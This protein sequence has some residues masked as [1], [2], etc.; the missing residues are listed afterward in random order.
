MPRSKAAN[1]QTLP[2]G[3]VYQSGFL[4]AGE[5]AA[6]LRE[7]ANLDFQPFHFQGY[8]ARRRIVS[9]GFEYDFSSRQASATHAIPGFL[10]PIQERAAG[11][12]GLQAQQ[13]V[14]AII[15]EYP[16]GAP[17]G[18]H[19]DVPQ[20]EIIIGIS[21]AGSCRMRFKPYRKEGG[22]ASLTLEPRSIYA[23]RGA[24]R[25]NYQHSI[26]AVTELRYSVT[27]RTPRAK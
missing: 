15:T 17:I 20:F 21:L 7:F 6:L 1:S 19:R 10:A 25:W 27:F 2:E 9:Y 4:S 16:A 12:A 22:I 11:W 24:A 23:M 14:E 5:E 26:P 13:I 3:F 8:T 18:W